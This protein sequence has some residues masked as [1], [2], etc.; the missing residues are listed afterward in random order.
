MYYYGLNVIIQT[1]PLTEGF[2]YFQ[3]QSLEIQ[4]EKQI[5]QSVEL[6]NVAKHQSLMVKTYQS[7]S[8]S[9][10]CHLF[11]LHP[12]YPVYPREQ[13]FCVQAVPAPFSDEGSIRLDFLHQEPN[14]FMERA[15]PVRVHHLRIN[16]C[17]IRN[18]EDLLHHELIT[19]YDMISYENSELVSHRFNYLQALP[20]IYND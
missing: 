4:E 17:N 2:C 13:F 14:R 5:H 19:G 3:K 12:K 18:L 9:K 1:P 6:L 16:H 7:P 20:V 8:H 15:N 10:I 11:T